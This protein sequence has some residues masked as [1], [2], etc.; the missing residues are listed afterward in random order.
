[1]ASQRQIRRHSFQ[2]AWAVFA[3]ALLAWFIL[4]G[5]YRLSAGYDLFIV[6]ALA[7]QAWLLFL[8]ADKKQ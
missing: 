8:S 4:R 6:I 3:I 5:A 7:A 2:L 1:M